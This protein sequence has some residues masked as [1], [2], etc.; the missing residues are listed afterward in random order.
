MAL[1]IKLRRTG[2]TPAAANIVAGELQLDTTNRLAYAKHTDNSVKAV[3]GPTGP[4]GPPGP[5]GPTG[6]TGSTGPTGP[7]GFTGPPGPPG[8]AC[9]PVPGGGGDASGDTGG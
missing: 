9:P 8:T 2:A 5:T 4:A 6:F 1:T 7:T 3:R